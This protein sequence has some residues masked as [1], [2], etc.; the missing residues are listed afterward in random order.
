MLHYRFAAV[1]ALMLLAPSALAGIWLKRDE[2]LRL[3]TEGPAWERVRTMAYSDFGRAIGG[4]NDNH[5][6]NTLGQALVAERL[7]DAQL[8]ERVIVNLMS[9]IDTD[10]SNCS[11]D[12]CDSLSISRNLVAYVLAA[13]T[14]DFKRIDPSRE[15]R[16]RA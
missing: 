14:I 15:S 10:E 3:P 7:E 8:R 12:F 11:G 2:L 6:G 4:H 16:F 13:D 1:L 9:A 5:D